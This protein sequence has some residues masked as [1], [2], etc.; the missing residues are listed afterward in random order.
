M[1]EKIWE[2]ARPEFVDGWPVDEAQE[3]KCLRALYQKEHEDFSNYAY[4][5]WQAHTLAL[6][7]KEYLVNYK[8]YTEL[9]NHKAEI[10][11]AI[12]SGMSYTEFRKRYL[13][14]GQVAE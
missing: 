11:K 1:S 4:T 2:T 8:D 6:N 5:A 14:V 12:D 3:L 7:V 13:F 9:A 10:V